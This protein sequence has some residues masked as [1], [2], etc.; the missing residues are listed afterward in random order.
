LSDNKVSRY[1][2]FDSAE[3]YGN[4][5]AAGSAIVHFI[6][7]N[8]LG[9]DREHIWFTTKLKENSTYDETRLSIR[10]SIRK[11]GLGYLDLYLLHSPYGGAEK[12]AE[13]WRAIEDAIEQREVRSGGV[14]NFG[15]KHMKELIASNP[16]HLPSV[17]Q[18]EVHPFNTRPELV[19]YC[20]EYGITIEAYAPLARGL[21]LKNPTI[22]SLSKHYG[23]TPA[24][25]M[26]RWSLQHGY[27][28]LPKSV[29]KERIVSNS[30][31]G[32][33]EISETD[34]DAMDSLDEYLVTDW[35]PTD[36][37]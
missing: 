20:K 27:V 21:R 14:S 24:Q 28:P 19:T 7:N 10:S 35:D 8:K 12:R 9:V 3:W 31:V 18:I 1:R 32:T 36:C 25:L 22:V 34:M 26:I 17:N 5:K 15:L 6:D 23:C 37:D 13:C 4:E 30:Q 33:F 2:G 29:G 11:S 16:R